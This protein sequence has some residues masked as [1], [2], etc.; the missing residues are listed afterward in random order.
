MRNLLSI[1]NLRT[2]FYTEKGV[3]KAVN[4][5]SFNTS[6]REIFGIVGESGSGKTV[7]CLSIMRLLP[8]PFARIIEGEIYFKGIDLLKIN[9][10]EMKGIRGKEISMI[11][12]E[13]MSSLNPVFSIGDQL[14]EVF[15]IHDKTNKKD[16]KERALEVL[17]LVGIPAAR[18]RYNE[19]PHQL[20]GGMQQRVM[21]AMA[22]S[23][24]PSLLIADEPT[25]NLDVT[26][27]MQILELIKSLQEKMK[28]AV[29]IIT[30]DL[31]I[32]AE[33]SGRIGVMY[34]GK[35]QEMAYTSDLFKN[36]LHP[37]TRGLLNSI[38]RIDIK[39]KR[40]SAIRGT[41][42]NP[43]YFPNGCKFHPRCDI[44]EERCRIEEPEL[45]KKDNNHFVRCWKV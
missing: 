29:I 26:I 10:K 15:Q 18:Q 38:P 40:Q 27:Q 23:T 24:A 35:I 13:P 41:V 4:G 1:K 19:Y 28:M 9:E 44:S 14:S 16:A 6:E 2:Y 39:Y 30:H 25:A 12:Q 43:L 20:S 34:A 17:N 7:T 31:G 42:P 37:Y 11:F 45:E 22:V 21:I 3:L 36:P 32:I 5:V 8:K 33:T